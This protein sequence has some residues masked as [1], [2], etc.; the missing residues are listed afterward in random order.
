M[1][2]LDI[3]LLRDELA[4]V[5]GDNKRFTQVVGEQGKK[6]IGLTLK[7]DQSTLERDQMVLE[8]DQLSTK[9]EQA[10]AKIGVL[11]NMLKNKEQDKADIDK[12]LKFYDNSH[13]PPSHKTITQR[14][15]NKEK[16]EERHQKNPE[17]RRGRKG[18]FKGYA[19]SRRA[20]QK[21]RHRPQECASCGGGNLK[22]TRIDNENAMDIPALPQAAATTHVTE[23]CRCLDCNHVTVPD[24]GLI[25]GTSLGPNLVKIALGMWKNKVSYQDIADT[26]SDLFGVKGCAKS[27]I[28]HALGAAADVME[29]ESRRIKAGM[30]ARTTPVNIDETPYPVMGRTGQ[31]WVATDPQSTVVVVSGSRGTAVLDAHFPYYQRPVTTDGLALYNVF[32]VRQRCWAHLFRDSDRYVRS[33]KHKT[34]VSQTDCRD[35]DMLHERLRQ[36]FHE[37][38]LMGAAT[39][40]QCGVLKERLLVIAASYPQ[41]LTNK[42]TSAADYLFIFLLHEGMEP[43]NNSVER[44]I[45]YPVIHRKVRGQI[46]S[47]EMMSRFG[48]LLTCILTWRKQKLNFYQEMD[49]ILLAHA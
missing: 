38:K 7:V 30:D 34:G 43:T 28:Q 47:K 31:V 26:L 24:A 14:E 40:S 5:I 45:R 49:R 33:A 6:I 2:N 46:G 20:E 48:T 37:A 36:L 10:N 41:K 25:K 17:G 9:L 21:I 42:L 32:E 39:V 35:A 12:V 27:T 13:T 11:V 23:T 19:V 29:P 3:K 18:G 44:E 1:S 16:K 15:I 4:K 22:V 8:R